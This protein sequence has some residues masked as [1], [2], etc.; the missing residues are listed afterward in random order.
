MRAISGWDGLPTGFVGVMR[1]VTDERRAQPARRRRARRD[2]AALIGA[3]G[4]EDVG[5]GLLEILGRRARLGRR[6]AVADG[7]RRA[8]APLPRTGPRPA[9]RLDRFMR[10]RR[11]ARL[12][13]R[14]RLPGPGL[15][16]ARA[17]V[18]GRH[19]ERRQA[20][21]AST[22]ALADG[23]RST[24]ALPLRAAGAPGRRDR[25]RLAHPARDRSP[26]SM[27][28]LE[29]I[30]GHVTQFLQRREAEAPRRRAGR[31]PEVA[32]H[33]RARAGGRDRPVRRPQHADAARCATSPAA[34]LG[35]PA[36][37]RPR[38]EE[39]DRVGRGWAPPCA[40]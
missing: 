22:R 10:R 37:S 15:D 17:A 8:P 11:H 20:R 30:G 40:G 34:A 4:L 13:G 1:D 18:E 26:A 14:R 2:A 6:R 31:R 38:G 35:R 28:L 32:V 23:I 7:R 19:R 39:L 5:P 25:A 9:S 36:R 27:R 16:V 24:V 3:D 29:A 21:A 33:G 12:R